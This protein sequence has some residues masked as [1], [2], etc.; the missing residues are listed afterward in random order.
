MGKVLFFADYIQSVELAARMLPGARACGDDIVVLSNRLSVVYQG[1]KRGVTVHLVRRTG[2]PSALDA[3]YSDRNYEVRSGYM[4][5]P[6]GR[7]LFNSY[8]AAGARLIEAEPGAF[9]LIMC[10]NGAHI[11]SE[12]SAALGKRYG[13]PVI[14]KEIANIPGRM[15]FDPEGSACDASVAKRPEILDD[16]P[17]DDATYEAW[18]ADFIAR[19]QKA[20]GIPQAKRFRQ[21]NLWFALDMLGPI[22]GAAPAFSVGP[23]HRVA[24][25]LRRK[26]FEPKVM[27][28]AIDTLPDKPFVFLPLQVSTDTNLVVR[29]DIDNEKAM[30]MALAEAD[31]RGAVLVTKIHPAERSGDFFRDLGTLLDAHN[32]RVI[33]T[34]AH[35]MECIRRSVCVVTINSTVGFEARMLGTEAIV[36]AP[37]LFS[38]WTN[39]QMAQFA[40]RYTV[41]FDMYST[42]DATPEQWREMRARAIPP[43]PAGAAA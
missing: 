12:V 40:L 19:R 16:F 41:P 25:I 7:V 27:A 39:R 5:A 24:N 43:V 29:S 4:T 14:Y 32:G 10:W 20:V 1:R 36:L 42:A 26:H 30:S 38:K 22:A 35:T 3:D 31:A 17:I 6:E 9:D 18:A 15:L 33:L 11:S 13:L 8:V 28:R 37:A 23:V 2:K 21:A 34:N